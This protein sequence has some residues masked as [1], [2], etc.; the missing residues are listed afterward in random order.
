MP[1]GADSLSHTRWDCCDPIIVIPKYRRKAFFKGV[2]KEIGEILRRLCEYQNGEWVTGSIRR[3]HVPIIPP[4][5][6]VSQCMGYLTGKSARMVC[7]R[8]PQMTPG[9][10]YDGVR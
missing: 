6:S 8:F 1:V 10:G 9:R 4:Q 2:R 5:C 3:D 7:D